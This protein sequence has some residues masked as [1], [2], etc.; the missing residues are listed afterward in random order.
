MKLRVFLP[1]SDRL[2]PSGRIPWMLF[3]SRRNLLRE[4]ASALTQMPRADEV[5]AVLPASRVL[6]ARLKLPKVN[7]ATIRELLPYAVEDR[8]LADPSQIHAVAGATDDKGETVVAVI[9]REWL[10]AMLAALARCGI[11]PARAWC[12]SALLAGGRGDWNLMLGGASGMLVDDDGVGVTFD[13]DASSGLPLALRIALDEA[14]ARGAR[15]QS[16]RVHHEGGAALPDLERWSAETGVPCTRGTQWETLARGEPFAAAVNLL[17]QGFAARPTGLAGLRVPRAALALA[18]VIVALQLVFIALDA[19]RL[20]RERTA[21]EAR[22][23]TV[24]RE[25][26]PDAKVVVDPELQMA[27]N[28]AELQRA[29]GLASGDDFLAS[30]TRAARESA[31]PLRSLEY[32]NG[33]LEVKRGASAGAQAAK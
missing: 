4:D 32:A 14:S 29:R 7:A 30:L 15:P 13:R 2:D 19:W 33:R 21:L 24:F 17:T 26:F 22:R 16:I 18:G 1:A 25:A 6:F 27:R 20:D 28:L 5:E 12:E 31:A 3:D 10:Q 23:E 11:H 8:L 9:D